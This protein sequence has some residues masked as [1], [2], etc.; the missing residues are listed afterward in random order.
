MSETK[1]LSDQQVAHNSQAPAERAG[2]LFHEAAIG[3]TTPSHPSRGRQILRFV[4]HFGE[5][6]LAMVL[7][8]V[9]LGVVNGLILV[10]LGFTYLSN[11]SV[12][13]STLAMVAA[14]TVPM[15]A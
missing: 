9:A 7:G 4:R 5:M 14:M 2:T 13:V 3:T 8:M 12:E 6:L 11:A 1:I 10:P 15:V